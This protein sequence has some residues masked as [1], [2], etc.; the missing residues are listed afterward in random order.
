MNILHCERAVIRER[1]GRV[2]IIIM[3]NGLVVYNVEII[4]I[5]P[6]IAQSEIDRT[7]IG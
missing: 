7:H 3:I 2:C 5:F 1:Y 4:S 6:V